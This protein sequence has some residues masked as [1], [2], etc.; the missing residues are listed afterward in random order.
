METEKEELLILKSLRWKGKGLAKIAL[1]SSKTHTENL[2]GMFFIHL[3]NHCPCH[4]L[5]LK[6]LITLI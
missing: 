2:D 3:C 1:D 5:C 6:M 4:Y